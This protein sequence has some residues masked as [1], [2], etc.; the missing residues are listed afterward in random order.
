MTLICSY[1]PR[2]PVFFVA[3]L[4]RNRTLISSA[5]CRLFSL[6]S[7]NTVRTTYS[8]VSYGTRNL[9]V[10]ESLINKGLIIMSLTKTLK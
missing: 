4:A 1:V 10:I 3:N 8:S 7:F 2:F 5:R 9:I 6:L